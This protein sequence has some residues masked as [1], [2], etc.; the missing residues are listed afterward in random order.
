MHRFSLRY[1]VTGKIRKTT[2]ETFAKARKDIEE[3]GGKVTYE[4]HSAMNGIEFTFPNEQVTALR[5]KAYVD[6]IEQDKTVHT[7]E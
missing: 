2:K 4:F 5:E 1:K 6:F 3:Q 7:F